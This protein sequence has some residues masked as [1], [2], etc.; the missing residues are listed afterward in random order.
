MPVR[1]PPFCRRVTYK[2]LAFILLTFVLLSGFGYRTYFTQPPLT[3]LHPVDYAQQ[4]HV[5]DQDILDLGHP[6]FADIRQYERTL[7]QHRM[8]SMF[9]KNRPRCVVRSCAALG[10]HST[11][12]DTCTFPTRPGAPG[13]P[14]TSL[15]VL[16]GRLT[17][18]DRWNNVFQEQYAE[19]VSCTS[20]LNNNL[21]RTVGS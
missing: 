19:P 7:P 6:T 5:L 9:T 21:D 3:Y 10:A 12:A 1:L 13:E 15:D 11:T 14:A 18:L 16:Y 17:S 8:P 20:F 2:A 4:D